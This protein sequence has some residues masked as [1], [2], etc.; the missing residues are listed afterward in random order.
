MELSGILTQVPL[1]CVETNSSYG[2]LL[3][4]DWLKEAQT[5]ANF[6][7]EEYM[8]GGAISVKQ[9][10]KKVALIRKEEA[11]E[12]DEEEMEDLEED[13]MVNLRWLDEAYL[14]GETELCVAKVTRGQDM[15]E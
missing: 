5:V 10:G 6:S 12:E 15:Q 14:E 11:S 1:R 3:G 13:V 2:V 4:M 7:E 8:L 9:V